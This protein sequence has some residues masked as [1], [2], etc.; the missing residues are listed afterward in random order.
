MRTEQIEAAVYQGKC[1]IR[2]DIAEGLVPPCVSSFEELH[3]HVDANEYG[4]ITEL[5]FETGNAVAAQLDSWLKAGRPAQ[6]SS[7]ASDC[8]HDRDV[9]TV[10]NDKTGVYRFC[11]E[12]SN[13]ID[14]VNLPRTEYPIDKIK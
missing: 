4:S 5:D 9:S 3:S 6:T 14:E 7:S 13:Y 12:C 8:K 10:Y 11:Y 2:A 1:Q